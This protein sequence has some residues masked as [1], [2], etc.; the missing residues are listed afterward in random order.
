MR[1]KGGNVEGNAD[2]RLKLYQEVISIE[3]YTGLEG[4]DIC[5]RR[6]RKVDGTTEVVEVS[7]NLDL[8]AGCL[9]SLIYEA[10]EI[11]VV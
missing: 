6:L 7:K 11:W 10:W 4:L 5:R 2:R 8:P 3:E 9:Y 1:D